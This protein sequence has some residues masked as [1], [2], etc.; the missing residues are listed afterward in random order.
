[1]PKLTTVNPPKNTPWPTA[2]LV[3]LGEPSP[4]MRGS[5]QD[6]LLDG[7]KIGR[8]EGFAYQPVRTPNTVG[9]NK[10][11]RTYPGIGRPSYGT[12]W[13]AL[14]VVIREHLESRA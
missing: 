11:W 9:V 13:Q 10:E 3:Q 7:V 1:M 12:R 6:V 2:G 8:V 14:R 4:T 5:V